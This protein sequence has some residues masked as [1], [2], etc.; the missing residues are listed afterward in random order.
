MAEEKNPIEVKGTELADEQLEQVSGGES[1]EGKSCP[2]CGRTL[3]WG[4]YAQEYACKK[5]QPEAFPPWD[6]LRV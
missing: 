2:T 3:E 5:C 4:D 1:L 6:R